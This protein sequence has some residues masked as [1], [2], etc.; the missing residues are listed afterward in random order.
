MRQFCLASEF[1]SQDRC[2]QIHRASDN[3]S[4]TK[5]LFTVKEVS[6]F[7]SYIWDMLEDLNI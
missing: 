7:I 6:A 3:V 5:R 4:V 2:K 1:P